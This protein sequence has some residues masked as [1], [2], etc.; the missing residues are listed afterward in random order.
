MLGSSDAP[1]AARFLE[2]LSQMGRVSHS[3]PAQSSEA[4]D[5]F[6]EGWGAG[7]AQLDQVELVVG[8]VEAVRLLSGQAERAEGHRVAAA[9][10]H[11]EDGA[12]WM[13]PAD[14]LHRLADALQEGGG[15]LAAVEAV[16]RIVAAPL[17][18]CGACRVTLVA[19][20]RAL[21]SSEVALVEAG[22]ALDRHG[23]V[24]QLGGLAAARERAAVDGVE[25]EAPHALR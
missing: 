23:A 16:G 2:S 19:Q 12:R 22:K 13:A 17:E 15:G 3:G 8:L 14:S 7:G 24:D 5:E 20:H 6:P 4:L 1:F 9:V 21:E 10:A 11:D 25:V 18:L